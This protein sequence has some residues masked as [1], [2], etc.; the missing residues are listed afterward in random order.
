MMHFVPDRTRLIPTA[1]SIH[2]ILKNTHFPD[3]LLQ[4]DHGIKLK[5]MNISGLPVL[6][7]SFTN[8]SYDFPEPLN[9]YRLG[10]SEAGWLDR[11]Q[12]AVK[13][14]LRIPSF[15]TGSMKRNLYCQQ[16]KVRRCEMISF[17]RKA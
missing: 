13:S 9:D 4:D 15:Q 16:K 14:S 8:S 17:I 10:N 6:F 5:V 1:D 11:D 2:I 7:F 3:N 12:I